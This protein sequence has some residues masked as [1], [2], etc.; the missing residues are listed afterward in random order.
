M[1]NLE[2][3]DPEDHRLILPLRRAAWTLRLRRAT[4]RKGDHN[5]TI[6]QKRDLDIEANGIEKGELEANNL[7]KRA[8]STSRCA[9]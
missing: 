9:T 7:D 6:L 3:R 4:L 1:G 5:S 2:A 8:A